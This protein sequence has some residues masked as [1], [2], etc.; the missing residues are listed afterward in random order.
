MISEQIPERLML[1]LPFYHFFFYPFL[2]KL[3]DNYSLL[4]L[5][6]SFW[7][8]YPLLTSDYFDGWPQYMRIQ[9]GLQEGGHSLHK[10]H[11][12]LLLRLP[13]TKVLR[14]FYHACLHLCWNQHKSNDLCWGGN[15]RAGGRFL[16]A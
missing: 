6:C 8:L 2:S 5:D 1:D 4:L 10:R 9:A 15:Q 3:L 7:L 11:L 14:C 12:H 13:S 16:H